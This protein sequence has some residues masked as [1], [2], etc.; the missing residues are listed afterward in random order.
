MAE[1]TW[2][3][4]LTLRPERQQFVLDNARMKLARQGLDFDGLSEV[5]QFRLRHEFVSLELTRWLKRVRKNSEA[6]L[7]FCLVA[8]AHKSGAPHYHVLVH[9]SDP[10]RPVRKS[11]LCEAWT[12]G[13]TRWKL[14]EDQRAAGYVTK[15]LSK[16]ALA[17]VRASLKYGTGGE[18]TDE[19]EKLSTHF[20]ASD[21]VLRPPKKKKSF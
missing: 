15:Y 4:T 7:R 9:E 2:F 3:G 13:F 12:W 20:V 17:R 18:R 16:S 6:P 1:R 5:E 8:E 21:S 11:V 14:V 10:A 19:I